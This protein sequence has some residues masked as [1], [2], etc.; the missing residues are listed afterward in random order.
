MYQPR[1]KI[2]DECGAMDGMSGKGYRSTQNL[3]QFPFVQF[4]SHMIWHGLEP[5]K[6]ETITWATVRPL[7]L[8]FHFFL[9]CN[10][11]PFAWVSCITYKQYS[12]VPSAVCVAVLLL[13]TTNRRM[14]RNANEISLRV[15]FDVDCWKELDL[16]P[17]ARTEIHKFLFVE[18]RHSAAEGYRHAALCT[19][20]GCMTSC[21][22]E[23]LRGTMGR[24]DA[25]IGLDSHVQIQTLLCRLANWNSLLI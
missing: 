5:G 25:F 7:K 10:C 20:S 6:S 4:K 19:V 23:L 1:M 9:L 21:H 8:H 24:A 18:L 22:T 17:F 13:H 12:R 2:H 11:F 15:M 16:F 3:P 14:A